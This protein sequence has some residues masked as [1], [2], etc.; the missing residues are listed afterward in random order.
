MYQKDAA[1]VAELPLSVAK[2]KRLGK[3]SVKTGEELND[4][5]KSLARKGVAHAKL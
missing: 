1:K 2:F 3:Y 5:V 4:F